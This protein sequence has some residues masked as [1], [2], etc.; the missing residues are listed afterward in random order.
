[1][2][3][4]LIVDLE[5]CVP[6]RS[7]HT[8]KRGEVARARCESRASADLQHRARKHHAVARFVPP[9]EF[10]AYEQVAYAKGFLLV[11]ATPLTRSSHHAG[12]DFRKLRERRWG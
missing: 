3:L 1:M 2:A 11:S 7:Q 12:D 9:D 10:K 6:C 5:P 4:L 8:A